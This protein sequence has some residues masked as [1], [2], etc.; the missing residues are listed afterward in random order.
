[1]K[2]A[3]VLVLRS[4]LKTAQKILVRVFVAVAKDRV[5]GTVVMDVPVFAEVYS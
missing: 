4:A 2:G 1:M 5:L 3:T